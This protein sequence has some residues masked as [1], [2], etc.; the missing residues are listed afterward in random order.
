MGARGRKQALD[1]L[2]VWLA[3]EA[4]RLV[5]HRQDALG[6]AILRHAPCLLGVAVNSD[7]WVVRADRHNGKVHRPRGA[8]TA[9]RIGQ[10]RVAAKHN[11]ATACLD[12]VAVVSAVS[13]GTQ[14]SAP[15]L[16]AKRSHGSRSDAELLVPSE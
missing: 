12:H 2:E 13:V 14:A 6:A 15:V 16:D 9:E 5:M 4:E 8:Q 10:R 3:A 11:A 7:P 1:G